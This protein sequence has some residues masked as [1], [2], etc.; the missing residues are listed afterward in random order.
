MRS[1][2]K[3]R[4]QASGVTTDVGGAMKGDHAALP[5][6]LVLSFWGKASPT[7]PAG[8]NSHSIAYHSL[9][10]AAVGAELIAHDRKRLDRISTAAGI[11]IDA[12]RG[13]LP[14]FFTLHDIGKYARVFQAKSPDNWPVNCLGPHR[15]VAPGNSHVVTGFQLLVAFSDGG[16]SCDVFEAVMPGWSAN[17][18]KILFRALAGHHGRPPDE[19]VG[20]RCSLGPHDVC[21][22]C[23]AAANT[24]I[25]AMFALLRPRALP[26]R[27]RSE[28]TILAVG[29]ADG[30]REPAWCVSHF[31]AHRQD[32]LPRGERSFRL[33]AA[34]YA[35]DKMKALAFM[36]AETPEI[37]APQ[38][39]DSVAQKAKDFV[40]AANVVAS[41][42]GQAVKMALYGDGA[43]IGADTTPL[44]TARDR[45]WAGTN[46]RFFATLNS[47]SR[48]PADALTGEAAVPLA[49]AWRVALERT[50]LA[51]FD[52]MA[53]V[54]DALS[55][56]VKRLVE[57]RRFLWRTLLGYGARGVELFKNLQ[58]AVPEAKTRRGKAA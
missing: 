12:L 45:F 30:L 49:Q 21:E 41:A 52:D 10:V 35:M 3:L 26:R 47:F 11:E 9:D 22:K 20:L 32:D 23:V 51:I 37:V 56:D 7:N 39:Q 54:Q 34:G 46:D 27:S 43:D 31:L 48:L 57:G 33:M 28:L 44:T 53:P 42:L 55:P 25:Q 16:S 24:H 36:E 14:F 6:P 8:I 13:T 18:R 15:E 50:A 40:A 29:L 1:R 38:A 5:T 4:G 19:G 58:L 17:E 2:L